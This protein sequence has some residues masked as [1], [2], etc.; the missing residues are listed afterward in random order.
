MA[1]LD[2]A[3]SVSSKENVSTA[4]SDSGS[5]SSLKP[6]PLPQ[7]NT[8]DSG[9]VRVHYGYTDSIGTIS[10]IRQAELYSSSSLN[11]VSDLFVNSNSINSNNNSI[12]STNNNTALNGDNLKTRLEEIKSSLNDEESDRNQ[13]WIGIINDYSNQYIRNL[14]IEEIEKYLSNGIPTNL[15]ALVYIK[16]IQVRYRLHHK[17]S[18]DNLVKKAKYSNSN[19]ELENYL[20]E[21]G[22]ESDLVDVLSVYN[23]YINEL[24]T[25]HVTPSITENHS[26]DYAPPSKFIISVAKILSKVPNFEKDEVF[27]ILLK[28]NKLLSLLAKD[29]FYYKISRSLEDI[30]HKVFLHISVQGIFLNDLYKKLL[31]NYFEEK[32]TDEEQLLKILDVIVFEGFDVILRIIVWA[33]IENQ[34]QILKLD[35]D[36][37]NNFIYSSEFFSS[38]NFDLNEVFK[39]EPQIIKYENEFHLM[40]ANSLNNNRNELSNLQEVNDELLIKINDLNRQLE[41]LQTTHKEILEQSEQFNVQLEA[42]KSQNEQLVSEQLTLQ[43]KLRELTMED[44]LNNTIQANKDFEERNNELELQIDELKK[45]IETKTQKLAKLGPIAPTSTQTETIPLSE[46]ALASKDTEP[47]SEIEVAKND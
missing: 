11:E 19:K 29:E 44:N 18:F 5:S 40:H 16:T 7:R 22:I 45:S 35:G 2:T 23:Y 4:I 38:L 46:E 17:E 33:F 12:N 8:A 27:Y 21:S 34:D 30:V 1:S 47:P 13:Y 26:A 25:T 39:H 24:V 15:R 28:F 10:I 32:I 42:A 31:F 20:Q 37:L 41:N 6:P 9:N 36:E 43:Q 14:K 3:V